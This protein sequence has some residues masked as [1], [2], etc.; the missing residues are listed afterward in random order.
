M[1]CVYSTSTVMCGCGETGSC[2]EAGLRCFCDK[3]DEE[4]RSDEGYI[5]NRADLPVNGFCAGDTGKY[6]F[7]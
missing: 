4:W 3:N 5:T 7:S 6:I 2:G 1:W